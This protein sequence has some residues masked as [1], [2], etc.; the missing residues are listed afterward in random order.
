MNKPLNLT[1]NLF[2]LDQLRLI[3]SA[4][5]KAKV[6][7]IYTSAGNINFALNFQFQNERNR[8]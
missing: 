8:N 5:K 1:A 3:A 6:I 4:M 7:D 2:S